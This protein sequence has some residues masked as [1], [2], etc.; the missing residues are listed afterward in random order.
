NHQL[1]IHPE[2]PDLHPGC[3]EGNLKDNPVFEDLRDSLKF[4]RVDFSLNI[5]L[6]N[7]GRIV[8]AVAGDWAAAHQKGCQMVDHL[9]RIPIQQKA[10]LVMVSCGGH[11]RDINFIQAHKA[12]QHG[13]YALKPGGTLIILAQ[14]P[15]GI[16]SESFLEWFD[17]PDIKTTHQALLEN[18]KINGNTALS[19]RQKTSQAH[20]ILVSD[21]NPH[22]VQK[23]GMMAARTMEE[24]YHQALK[25][26]PKDYQIIVIP[27]GSLTVPWL[28]EMSSGTPAEEPHIS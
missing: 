4:V 28:K 6:D 12:I 14:C 25:F 2:L 13:F 1:T 19:L 7:Q 11:P 22:V 20:L 27:N 9:Y 3:R 26:L 5:I 10:D 24:A 8:Q 23:M 18:F 21:L 17:Y 16:G 15:E